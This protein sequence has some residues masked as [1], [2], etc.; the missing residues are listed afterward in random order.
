[1]LPAPKGGS[2]HAR[3]TQRPVRSPRFNAARP[4][5]RESGSSRCPPM[6]RTARFN[7]ARPEGRESDG[8]ARPDRRTGARASMLPAPKG[9]SRQDRAR[10]PARS[11]RRFNA[12]RP[13]GRESAA[14]PS[15]KG[16]RRSR[17]NA[18]RP[19]GRESVG[20]APPA[21]RAASVASM[22]PAPKGGS[23]ARRRGSG[24][25]GG[26]SAS[27]LPAPKGGSRWDGLSI[28]NTSGKLQC[29]PPRR[30]GVGSSNTWAPSTEA[31]LQCCPPR[32]A[33]VGWRSLWGS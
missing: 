28:A 8:A 10:R 14:R 4:E 32:R 9:G 23:R 26:A 13:E 25:P 6:S 19:E 3:R 16:P 17:F 18:A 31:R 1:M 7:A 27:M 24:T 33:G 20:D 21:G 30:A 29:C 5:G 15:L 12:A 22:L 2:R 11:W